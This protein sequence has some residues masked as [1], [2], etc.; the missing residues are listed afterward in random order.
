M[1][2]IPHLGIS[3]QLSFILGIV[4]RGIYTYI[5]FYQFIY[6]GLTIWKQIAIFHCI[7][8]AYILIVTYTSS[9]E[10]GEGV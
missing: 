8:A 2:L 9:Y 6:P 4:L 1:E 3:V 10:L 7:P 5:F